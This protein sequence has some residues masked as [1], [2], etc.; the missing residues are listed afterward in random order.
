MYRSSN[1]ISYHRQLVVT[2]FAYHVSINILF[3]RF[4]GLGPCQCFYVCMPVFK[5][6]I[7]AANVTYIQAFVNKH[8]HAYIYCH[9]RCIE[10]VEF[11]LKYF[12]KNQNVLQS[13]NEFKLR[14][15][16]LLQ[17]KICLT[18]NQINKYN[19]HKLI[20]LLVYVTHY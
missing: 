1:I 7:L 12:L 15:I 18:K 6:L 8:T 4:W 10:G 13:G 14:N 9:S 16:C 17:N 3:L 19:S 11:T 2:Y 20:E 5:H